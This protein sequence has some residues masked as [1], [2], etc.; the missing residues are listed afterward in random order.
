MNDRLFSICAN[1]QCKFFICF[2]WDY[3][4]LC[5]CQ[6]VYFEQQI[7]QFVAVFS[8]SFQYLHVPVAYVIH[9]VKVIN[10]RSEVLIDQPP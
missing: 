2:D 6:S 1:A 8:G 10:S 9:I 3:F 5:I 7:L 4:V